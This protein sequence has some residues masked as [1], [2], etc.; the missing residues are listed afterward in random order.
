MYRSF[1]IL[2]LTVM[3]GVTFTACSAPQ[4][5]IAEDPPEENQQA[6]D[7]DTS[8]EEEKSS[9]IDPE[10]TLQKKDQGETVTELQDILIQVGYDIS[11]TS[12]YD[13]D[14]VWAV[15]DFQLQQEKLIVSGICDADTWVALEDMLDSGSSIE[16]GAGLPYPAETVAASSGTPVIGNPYDQLALI[17]KSHALPED[18]IPSDLVTPNVRFPFDE[19][20][21][22]KK[23]R[24]G[25]AKSLEEMFQAADEAGLTLYAQSGYRSY[26]RQQE[27]FEA[28]AEAHG[29][30]EANTFSARPGESEH[31]T[32][33]T[34]DITS[35][36]INFDLITE[37]GDTPE[38]KWVKENA[39]D[40]GFI[41]RYPEGKED[42][43]DYQYEPWHLRYV[44]IK[45]A[46]EIMS[47][48]I[49]LEEYLNNEQ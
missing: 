29:E 12:I 40:F 14:T 5:R 41:I 27:I 9:T 37:F 30:A 8:E 31:Q 38:G 2:L 48:G 47:E 16:A 45:A 34:M 28:N 1:T 3:A 6:Q 17:N 10:E 46:R 13:E 22:K 7:N 39:A 11:Q 32:G 21:P 33:L 20:L 42:I 43:T 35:A 15:T 23:M 4:E 25:A 24:Q 19:D 44:G 18:Y 26:E 36:D 49:T